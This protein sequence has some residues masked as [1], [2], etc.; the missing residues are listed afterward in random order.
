MRSDKAVNSPRANNER[1]FH[2]LYVA[3]KLMHLAQKYILELYFSLRLALDF[4]SV[5][6]QIS[7]SCSYKIVLIKK[8]GCGVP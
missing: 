1:T 5:F 6:H 4:F 2:G 8:G 3:G 7:S